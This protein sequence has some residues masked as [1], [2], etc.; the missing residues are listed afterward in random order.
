[1]TKVFAEGP[2]DF[3]PVVVFDIGAAFLSEEGLFGA[4]AVVA[5]NRDLV[6]GVRGLRTHFASGLGVE[7]CEQSGA[8]FVAVTHA[9]H[10]DSGPCHIAHPGREPDAIGQAGDD[11]AVAVS[12]GTIGFAALGHTEDDFTLTPETAFVFGESG[13]RGDAP[14]VELRDFTFDECVRIECAAPL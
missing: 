5:N 14:V 13:R 4:V 2:E 1:M 11:E 8:G 3:A 7:V 6:V 10:S 9:R 12:I